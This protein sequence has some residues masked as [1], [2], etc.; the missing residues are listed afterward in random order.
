MMVQ[1]HFA[2]APKNKLSREQIEALY[3]MGEK[4]YYGR[5]CKMDNKKATEYFLQ[6]A[7]AG[8]AGAQFSLGHMYRFGMGVNKDLQNARYWLQQ[9]A[10]KGDVKAREYLEAMDKYGQ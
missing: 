3:D 2:P 8:H 1:S 6:A 4:Y 10:N 7:N 9:A 5:G